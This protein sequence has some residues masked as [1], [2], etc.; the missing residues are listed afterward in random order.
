MC[1]NKKPAILADL[2]SE[3]G[4]ADLRPEPAVQVQKESLSRDHGGAVWSEATEIKD[5]VRGE[6]LP[7]GPG[8]AAPFP[9]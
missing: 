6:F 8:S 7:L 9:L 4:E 2:I 1:K 3:K 5:I